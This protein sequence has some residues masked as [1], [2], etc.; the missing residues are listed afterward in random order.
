MT[1]TTSTCPTEAHLS[2][3]LSGNLPQQELDTAFAHIDGCTACQS[4]I[5]QLDLRQKSSVDEVELFAVAGQPS[6]TD[7]FAAESA[8][9]IGMQKL[10]GRAAS[11]LS[12]TALL[13]MASI[14]PYRLIRPLGFGGMGTVYLGRHDRLQRDVAIKLLPRERVQT[15]GWLE[16]FDR[17]MV[18]VAAIEHPNV[19][20]ATDAGVYEGWHYFVM[21]YLNGLDTGRIAR[22]VGQLTVADACEILRQAALGLD[23]IHQQGLV[24]RDIKPSNLM[25]TRSG[26]VKLL[27]LGL[28]LPGDDP[29]GTDERLTTV[30]HLLGTIG[31]MAPEQL[32]DCRQVDW[33]ADLYSLGATLYRL[34]AGTLPHSREQGLAAYILAITSQPPRPLDYY[35]D[36]VDAAVV[37]LVDRL[38]S[39]QP[40]QRPESA[41]EVARCLAAPAKPQRLKKLVRQAIAQND[42]GDES[43]EP[44]AAMS[45]VA[46]EKTMAAGGQQRRWHSRWPLLVALLLAGMLALGAIVL[47][48]QT[49]RGELVIHSEQDDLTIVVKQQDKVVERLEV[50]ATDVGRTLLRKGTYHV[51][52]EGGGKP[53]RLSDDV[54]TIARGEQAVVR[55]EHGTAPEA[56]AVES[57]SDPQPLYRSKNLAQWMRELKLEQSPTELGH[58]MRAAE[59]LSRDTPQRAAVAREILLPARRWGGITS[60]GTGERMG[61]A[62]STSD[63]EAESG[64]YMAFLLEVFPQFLPSPG[65]EVMADELRD[66]NPRSRT[67]CVWLLHNGLS[68][69]VGE[70]EQPRQVRL[71]EG[72]LAEQRA[73]DEGSVLASL[74]RAYPAVFEDQRAYPDSMM[75]LPTGA[76]LI[77]AAGQSITDHPWLVAAI[78]TEIQANFQQFNQEVR[79][80]QDAG[81][82]A[83]LTLPMEILSRRGH[84]EGFSTFGQSYDANY[85]DGLTVAVGDTRAA[86]DGKHPLGKQ[87][88]ILE[89]GN[90]GDLTLLDYF[91]WGA[92]DRYF[93]QAADRQQFRTMLDEIVSRFPEHVVDRTEERLRTLTELLE[94]T[95]ME[96]DSEYGG[97]MYFGGM[98]MGMGMGSGMPATFSAAPLTV[99]RLQVNDSGSGYLVNKYAAIKTPAR[100]GLE[101]LLRL[102]ASMKLKTRPGQPATDTPLSTAIRTIRQ[103]VEKAVE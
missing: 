71:I 28:V 31:Y 35:R 70:M 32:L 85:F 51:E 22:R 77:R 47:K 68:G 80:L 40:E 57:E 86:S 79:R 46:S 82:E 103:R 88:L 54:V 62:V 65:F 49:D 43:L 87:A 42:S 92:W 7:P 97:D 39:Q 33:R 76:R 50:T 21:E 101:L 36:D 67:A 13:P 12:P 99:A 102:E 94:S 4:R 100:E 6:P 96:G 90:D 81:H 18:T 93:S 19:V 17:E 84:Y 74:V 34:L 56:I 15:P 10:V 2:E 64:R 37:R 44:I 69:V 52:I 73:A 98:G 8:C 27:D 26:Q 14:G 5:E 38:L 83:P 20:R 60:T 24:H 45:L 78:R 55:V 95:T 58:A 66:G 91:L 30:G 48:I 29:L 75:T 41:A 53:L 72:W 3:V 11:G 59:V 61:E 16:R 89:V 25:L 1:A 9:Q 23:H 63:P